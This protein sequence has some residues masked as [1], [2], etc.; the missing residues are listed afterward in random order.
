MTFDSRAHGAVL[1]VALAFGTACGGASDEPIP[2]L[3]VSKG[4]VVA[5]ATLGRNVFIAEALVDGSA[6]ANVIIDTG[7]PVSLL[8]PDAFGGKVPEGAGKVSTL[9]IGGITLTQVPILGQGR[10]L[11]SRNGLPFGGFLGFS[12]FGQFAMSFN[13]RDAQVAFGDRRTPAMVDGSVTSIPFTL[14]GGGLGRIGDDVI[15]VPRSRVIVSATIEGAERRYVVDTGASLMALRRA[16]LASATADG[17][18]TIEVPVQLVAGVSSATVTRLRSVVVGGLEVSDVAAL[19]SPEIDP[20]LESVSIETSEPVA[21]LIGG[22]F[23]REF[24]TTVDYPAGRLDLRRYG[25]REHVADEYRRVGID[26]AAVNGPPYSHSIARVFPGT[27]AAAQAIS[28][29][30]QLTSID[31]IA[32]ENLDPYAADRLLL[33]EVGTTRTLVIEGRT[34]VVRID[35]L[36]P[37]N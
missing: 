4:G 37:F 7:A 9:T 15:R 31:G 5:P 28:V 27:D 33:G 19:A 34:L 23:L 20:L 18:A 1:L 32:L 10:S 21:G 13:Y 26:L 16:D 25:S 11:S 14:L 35:E 12:A 36:L 17:R 6:R 8:A 3:W 29:G 22:T 24:Y 2:L 30:N